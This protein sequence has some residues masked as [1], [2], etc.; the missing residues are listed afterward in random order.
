MN[1]F[2][3]DEL[4]KIAYCVASYTDKKGDTVYGELL[5]KIRHL[6]KPGR[7]TQKEI[8]YYLLLEK[9]NGRT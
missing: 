5:S 3:T 6:L 8:D 2:S 1:D 4:E 7:M 9:I